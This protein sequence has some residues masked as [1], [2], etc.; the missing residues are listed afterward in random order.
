MYIQKECLFNVHFMLILVLL[1]LQSGDVEINPDP[2]A[3]HHG[4]L[5]SLH[6]N[7]RSVRNKLDYIK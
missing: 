7:I 5:S 1:L 3:S 6:S 2:V 4:S